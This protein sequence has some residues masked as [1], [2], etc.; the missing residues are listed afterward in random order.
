MAASASLE[1]PSLGSIQGLRAEKHPGVE[2]YLG[3]QFA[4]LANAF[5]RG[6]LVEKPAASIVATKRG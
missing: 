5:A 4:T 3:I 2:Q 6:V 1:H